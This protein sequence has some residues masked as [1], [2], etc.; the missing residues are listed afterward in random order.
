[1][2]IGT[3]GIG[4]GGSTARC[5]LGPSTET[6]GGGGIGEVD[7]DDAGIDSGSDLSGVLFGGAGGTCGRSGGTGGALSVLVRSQSIH[8]CSNSATL[9]MS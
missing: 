1:V 9:A 7:G 6:V 3:A 8:A 5:T 2:P 4:G